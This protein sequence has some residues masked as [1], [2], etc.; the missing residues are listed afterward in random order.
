MTRLS[1][2][3]KEALFLLDWWVIPYSMVKTG[4]VEYIDAKGVKQ[5][6][7]VGKNIEDFS[8]QAK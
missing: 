5:S 1:S 8:R 7:V 3:E 2:D 6:Q 4:V